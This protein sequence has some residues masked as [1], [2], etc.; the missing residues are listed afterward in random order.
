MGEAE[1]EHHHT[2]ALHLR[3]IAYADDLE[4]AR[5][6]P[7]N[8]FDGVVD[9]GARQSM[10]RGLGIILPNRDQM[11][12]LLFHL[13]AARQQRFQFALGT[14]HGN[15]VAF[16]LDRNTLRQRNRFFSNA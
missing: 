7:G 13:N 15:R 2:L 16:Y 10:D 5:P 6:A 14:L 12:I 3:A 1:R 11:P 4:F 9:Q 8:A